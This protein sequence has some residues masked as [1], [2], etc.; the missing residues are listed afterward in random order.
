MPDNVRSDEYFVATERAQQNLGKLDESFRRVGDSARASG[1]EAASA[2]SQYERAGPGGGGVGRGAGR[3]GIGGVTAAA[4][5]YAARAGMGRYARMIPG[6]GRFAG[7]AGAG[8]AAGGG[9]GGLGLAAGIGGA[10]AYGGSWGLGKVSDLFMN[11]AASGDPVVEAAMRRYEEEN[12]KEHPIITGLGFGGVTRF[13]GRMRA[14]GY[15]AFGPRT[16]D[17]R[18]PEAAA[19]YLVSMEMEDRASARRAEELLRAA[20]RSESHARHAEFSPSPG[21]GW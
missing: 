9:I 3:G 13:G 16:E 11:P 14:R 7:L 12:R 20:R 4:G 1:R 8:A 18:D 2:V 10:V 17:L 19:Q 15:S 21:L 5:G 6:V